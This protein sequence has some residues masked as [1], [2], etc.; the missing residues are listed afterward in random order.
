MWW[1]WQ[2]VAGTVVAIA[3]PVIKFAFPR[4]VVAACESSSVLLGVVRLVITVVHN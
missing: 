2:L 1:V 4:Q 3:C